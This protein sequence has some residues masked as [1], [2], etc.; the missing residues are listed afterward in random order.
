MV[1]TPPKKVRKRGGPTAMPRAVDPHKRLR[2]LVAGGQLD[3]SS[4]WKEWTREGSFLYEHTDQPFARWSLQMP[5]EGVSASTEDQGEKFEELSAYG[6]RLDELRDA[7]KLNEDSSWVQWWHNGRTYCQQDDDDETST[8]SLSLCVPEEG[9]RDSATLIS[10]NPQQVATFNQNLAVADREEVLRKAGHLNPESPWAEW[11]R[12][13]RLAS[14][15]GV[16][17]H[18]N[19]DYV[20][21]C[22]PK[23]GVCMSR[24]QTDVE[25]Y[26]RAF[27]RAQGQVKRVDELEASGKLRRQ[28][29]WTELSCEGKLCY[30]QLDTEARGHI[31]TIHSYTFILY[32]CI[33]YEY[34]LC[35]LLSLPEVFVTL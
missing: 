32:E 26:E 28:S 6:K 11:R 21:A 35:R 25:V 10:S 18:S 17:K 23:Q 12:A 1:K 14:D 5:E 19:S 31:Y 13:D 34:I 7:K 2:E 4:P 22:L 3:Q 16:Y 24:I 29:Q 30:L 8:T 33:V 15:P 27:A 20:T 9:V